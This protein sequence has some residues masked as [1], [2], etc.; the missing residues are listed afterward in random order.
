MGRT[1]PTVAGPRSG[2]VGPRESSCEGATRGEHT[3]S[4]LG[5]APGRDLT[6]TVADDVGLRCKG[7]DGW[8]GCC[9]VAHWPGTREEGKCRIRVDPWCPGLRGVAAE[10]ARCGN[11]T[12]K[13]GWCY[14][15]LDALGHV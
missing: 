9:G 4:W 13:T 3:K 10:L 12:C 2:T 6:S 7:D 15:S 11:S 14:F 1:R 5:A 8:G